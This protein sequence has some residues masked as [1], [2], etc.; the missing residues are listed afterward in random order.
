M[1]GAKAANEAAP[2]QLARVP[3]V[4]GG[5]DVDEQLRQRAPAAGD[6]QRDRRVLGGVAAVDLRGAAAAGAAAAEGEDRWRRRR[7][8][9]R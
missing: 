6:A 3:V 7:Q 2:D 1:G 8:A 9:G 4:A 5:A